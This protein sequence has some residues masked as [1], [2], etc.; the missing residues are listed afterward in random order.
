MFNY[1]AETIILVLK[2]DSIFQENQLQNV[3]R[4]YMNSITL[5]E[6]NR[7]TL[8]T[9]G[10]TNAL[11]KIDYLLSGHLFQVFFILIQRKHKL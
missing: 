8:N 3:W 1:L 10:L 7:N 2:F 6:K 9:S 11:I 5:A 4:Q